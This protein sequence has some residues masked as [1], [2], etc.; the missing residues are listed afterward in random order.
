MIVTDTETLQDIYD[1]TFKKGDI[2]LDLKASYAEG[3]N[4]FTH[5]NDL[6]NIFKSQYFR[7]LV[8]MSRSLISNHFEFFY[9]NLKPIDDNLQDTINSYSKIYL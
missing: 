7:D 3:W 9:Q 2:S 4:N 8:S 1:N 5:L 6:I